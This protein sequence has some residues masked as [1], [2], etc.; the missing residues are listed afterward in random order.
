MVYGKHQIWR[1]KL[2]IGAGWQDVPSHYNFKK[3]LRR[4]RR[5]HP[6][7]PYTLQIEGAT[8]WG[9][10]EREFI[11][12]SLGILD[13]VQMRIEYA[14][15]MLELFWK[16]QFYKTPFS[17]EEALEN[18]SLLRD[19]LFETFQVC[20]DWDQLSFYNIDWNI[21]DREIL[22]IQ[23]FKPLPTEWEEI[24][25][26]RMQNFFLKR[27]YKYLDTDAKLVSIKLLNSKSEVIKE[28]PIHIS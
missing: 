1:D 8:Y 3:E 28:Y 24:I 21:R 10:Y 14:E 15:D 2:G 22:N 26:T 11:A 4:L 17:F 6:R 7:I 9:N 27:P 5:S 19:Y 18:Y 23:L 25:I 13:D 20:D 12:Y 16:E